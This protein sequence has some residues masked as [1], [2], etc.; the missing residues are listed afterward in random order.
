[1]KPCPECSTPVEPW[2][3][4]CHKCAKVI[5][6]DAVP[7]V[8][9]VP[10]PVKDLEEAIESWFSRGQ[11]NIARGRYEEAAACFQEAIKRLGGLANAA[12]REIELR[13]RLAFA[14]EKSGKY[15]EAIE[16]YL[17]IAGKTTSSQ[18]KEELSERVSKLEEHALEV[19]LVGTASDD[20]VPVTA[21]EARVVPLYCQ[22]CKRLL[23]EA[24]IYGFRKNNASLVRCLCGAERTPLARHDA[25]HKRALKEAQAH[26]GRKAK[27][28]DAA[29]QKFPGG[30]INVVAALLAI[31]FGDFGIHKF[32]LGE[33]SA[34]F[35]YAMFCWTFIPWILSLFEAVHY[36]TMS[37]VS[38]NLSYNVERVLASIPAEEVAGE[39]HNELFAMQITEDPEDFVDEFT[40]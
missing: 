34:C 25:K 32:Y 1:M 33:R 5:S 15:A 24:E 3:V 21:F 7:V 8:E 13:Y 4:T 22:D 39:A 35:V 40:N 23:A 16:Q 36:L 6:L 19:A 17:S 9:E 29:S 28:I 31:F 18:I 10:L 14:L 2:E 11:E 27:L 12:Q 20:Y 26:E 30:K 38:W 37:R